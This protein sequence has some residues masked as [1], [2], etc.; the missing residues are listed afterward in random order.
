MAGARPRALG[1]QPNQVVLCMG[2]V[3]GCL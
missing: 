3:G 2:Q 1:R